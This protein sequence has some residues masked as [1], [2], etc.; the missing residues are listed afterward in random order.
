MKTFQCGG[1]DVRNQL[2]VSNQESLSPKF[3]L[4]MF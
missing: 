3:K 4:P 2:S 1:P